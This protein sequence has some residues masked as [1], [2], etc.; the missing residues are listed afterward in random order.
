MTTV[1]FVKLERQEKARLLCQLA[2][3]HFAVGKRVIIKVQDDNR[4]IS[5]DRFLWSWDK[6]AFLPHAFN[7][8]SVDCL[9]EPI[10]ITVREENPNGAPVLI[11]GEPC[12]ADY[13][14]QFQLVIDFAE[15]YDKQLAE[16]SRERFRTYRQHG[17]NPQ[18]Y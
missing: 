13:I 12:S 10:V 11:M 2:D 9:E 8:G 15:L 6:G 18:M 14:R 1:K 5:L 3:D 7:N 16:L 17:F 4:A